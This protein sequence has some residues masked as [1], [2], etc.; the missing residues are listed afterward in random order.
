MRQ[1]R[2]S[3]VLQILILTVVQFCRSENV[4]L[5]EEDAFSML[6]RTRRANSFFEETR[7]GNLERECIFEYCDYEEAR[8]VFE[9]DQQTVEFWGRYNA[10][11]KEKAD[12]TPPPYLRD[13][14]NGQCYEEGGPS[15]KG[16]I[17]MTISGRQCQSWSRNFPHKAEYNPV[18]YN[19]SDLISNYCR[20]PNN[21]QSGPWCYTKDPKVK[22]ELCYIPRCGEPLKPLP[23]LPPEEKPATDCVPNQGRDYTGTL[24]K[25]LSGRYC[26]AWSSQSPHKHNYTKQNYPTAGLEANYCR[27]PDDDD[28]GVWCYTTDRNKETEYCKLNYCDDHENPFAP[29]TLEELE[30]QSTFAGRTTKTEYVTSFNPEYFGNG[31]SECGLRRLFELQNKGDATEMELVQSLTG[32]IVKG[33]EAEIGSAPWQ[34]MLFQIHPQQL[35]C[36]GSILSDRWIITAAHCILY[37]PWNKNFSATDIVARLGKHVRAQYEH[38]REKIVKLDKIIVHPYYNWQSNLNRDI[39]L[40]HTTTPIPFN[41]YISPICLP[42]KEVAISLLRT[43]HMGRVTGWGN[44]AESFVNINSVK[45]QELQQIHLPIVDQEICKSS[46]SIKVTSNMFCAGFSPESDRRGDACEGDSGGPFVMKNPDDNRWYLIGIVSWGEGCDR[47]GK[48]GF[49]THVFKLKRWLR[50]SI[51]NFMTHS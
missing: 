50:K 6:K 20:N 22:M 17:S 7:S 26:Q 12:S 49:Y 9:D 27:N 23:T 34:V 43:H 2:D 1:I 25:T 11:T 16:N 36:G 38:S 18:T 13:C 15:Y 14:L 39:A 42:S 10:C 4:F 30:A 47:D 46:T 21:S 37:P 19:T 35:I 45:A 32:R 33:E 44:L 31:E 41:D 8:E 29:P 48:Y 24:N 28:E 5:A 51:R 3:L 40:L